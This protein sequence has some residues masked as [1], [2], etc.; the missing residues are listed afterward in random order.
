VAPA[1][2]DRLIYID[3]SGRPQSGVAVYGWVEFHPHHWASVLRGWLEMRKRLWREFR[4]PVVRE[5]HMTEYAQGRGR[6]STRVPDRHV[7]DGVDYWKDFGREVAQECL[8]TLRCIEGLR[9]GAVY[10][11]GD[12]AHI[13][14]LKTDTYTELV[15]R[16]ETE[17]AGSESLALLFMD[18]DGTD[19]TYRDSHRGLRL[20][21]RR[22]IED[23]VYTDSRHSQLM[24]MADHVAWCANATIDQHQ[25]SAFAAGWYDT[26]LAERDPTRSPQEI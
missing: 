2:L 18:G 8:E 11:W 3:D 15:S 14:Q 17:L 5:L 25:G 20:D 13:A 23:P 16:L 12:P 21:E 9:V 26:Y 6:I 19:T 10:R 22:V 7:H 1:S 24:Q 4:I